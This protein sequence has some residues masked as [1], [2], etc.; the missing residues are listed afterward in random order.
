[1]KIQASLPLQQVDGVRGSGKD[2]RGRV[3]RS[4]GD[5]VRLSSEARFIQDLRDAAGS[6]PEV[7]GE[8]VAQARADIASGNLGTPE[9]IEATIDGI[10]AGF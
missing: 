9:D 8:A 10:L 2:A 5:R 1:M 3:D 4:G 7:R 6:L